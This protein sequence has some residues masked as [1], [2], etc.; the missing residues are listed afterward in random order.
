[1]TTIFG[2]HCGWRRSSRRS[3]E[4]SSG[5]DV[6]LPA[7]VKLL[8]E[9]LEIVMYNSKLIPNVSDTL[10]PLYRLLKQYV[11][12]EW[13]SESEAAFQNTKLKTCSDNTYTNN[14]TILI[15]W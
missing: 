12:Y 1:M 8:L 13:T 9:F 14:H 11:N 10:S 15:C 2:T 5:M 6:A 3:G 4:S 7:N